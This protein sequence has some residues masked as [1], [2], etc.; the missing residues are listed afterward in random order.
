MAEIEELLPEDSFYRL[1]AYGAHN[2]L[3]LWFDKSCLQFFNSTVAPSIMEFYPEVGV[4]RDVNSKPD[5]QNYALRGS[6]SVRYTLVAK[7]SV[8]DWNGEN[9]TG[10]TL[11]GETDAYQIYHNDNW[12][13]MGF[14][15]EYYVTPEQ[16]ETVPQEE[17]AQILMRALLLEEDQIETYAGLLEPLPEE[18]LVRRDA[19]T[20]AADC[21]D[22]RA[23]A[24]T[25][26][27]ATDTGFTA[28]TNCADQELVFFSVPWD[29]GFTATVNEVPAV[30]EKVD[31][32]L[33]AILVPEGE[34]EI[35][36]TYHTPG[37]GLSAGISLAGV[38]VYGVYILLLYRRRKRNLNGKSC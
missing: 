22:R 21:A 35:Q 12:V 5:V 9:L 4:T 30:V 10:W 15:Y 11:C 20:Y 25:S 26:F 37:L 32:G 2:N 34:A 27:T 14:T 7:D 17:R 23:S 8:E 33:M 38:A 31:N 19:E 16:L 36:C 1:D 6:L 13:P 29:A 18:E 24:V 3:G 28:R